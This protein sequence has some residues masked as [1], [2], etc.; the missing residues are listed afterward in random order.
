[1]LICV[2]L[3]ELLSLVFQLFWISQSRSY[4]RCDMFRL[5]II[6]SN[7]GSLI[8]LRPHKLKYVWNGSVD[9][10]GHFEKPPVITS[11]AS[12]R[13]L[14]SNKKN[15][16]EL[17]KAET[18]TKNR[19][20]KKSPTLC[21]SDSWWTERRQEFSMLHQSKTNNTSPMVCWAGRWIHS[22]TCKQV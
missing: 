10:P 21:C 11:W 13:Y 5:G 17:K 20:N 8:K 1:M 6:A 14:R 19:F 12:M 15:K 7:P 2:S 9:E 3:L 18:R 16:I 4:A 22:P